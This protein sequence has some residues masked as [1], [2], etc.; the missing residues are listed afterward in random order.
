MTSTLFAGKCRQILT[1]NVAIPL[2]TG[3]KSLAQNMER[4]ELSGPIAIAQYVVIG[5]F[6]QRVRQSFG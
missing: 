5:R 2:V 4:E 1:K 6:H 3:G